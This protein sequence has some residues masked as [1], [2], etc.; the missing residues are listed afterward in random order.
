MRSVKEFY[1]VLRIFMDFCYVL[2]F[3]AKF[4][5][6]KTGAVGD[7]R[8]YLRW[9]QQIISQV[10]IVAPG[11]DSNSYLRCRQKIIAQVENFY[12]FFPVNNK[13]VQAVD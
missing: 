3:L 2:S 6:V 7:S 13:A 11:S 12:Y 10:Y 8:S 1:R 4:I 5:I 9:R